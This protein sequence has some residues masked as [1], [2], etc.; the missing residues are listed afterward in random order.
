M[1]QDD[2]QFCVFKK[3]TLEGIEKIP[4]Q[5]KETVVIVSSTVME[6][7]VRRRRWTILKVSV[8][9]LFVAWLVWAL[10]FAPGASV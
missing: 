5:Q 8:I 9:L 3:I 6:Q 2:G 10:I 7:N 1:P 4:V